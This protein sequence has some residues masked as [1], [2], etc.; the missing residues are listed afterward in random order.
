MTL[1]EDNCDQTGTCVLVPPEVYDNIGDLTAE[2][3]VPTLCLG[4]Q[5]SREIRRLL[6]QDGLVQPGILILNICGPDEGNQNARRHP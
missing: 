2:I 1:R 4:T 3:P 5:T 6:H